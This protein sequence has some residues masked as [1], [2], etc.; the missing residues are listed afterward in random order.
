MSEKEQSKYLAT[1]TRLENY[2]IESTLGSGGFSYV[3]LAHDSTTEEKV[4][5]KEYFPKKLTRRKPDNSV[6]PTTDND[7]DLFMQG[8]KLFLHEAA[9]LAALKHP[10]IVRVFNFFNAANVAAS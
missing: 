4:V 2:V 10:N 9:T 7:M 3:Y 1:D 8:R 5:I 6:E